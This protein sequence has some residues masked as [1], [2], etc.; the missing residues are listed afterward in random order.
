M[1]YNK[2]ESL[3]QYGDWDE[4]SDSHPAMKWMHE[5]TNVYDK[6]SPHPSLSLL[7]RTTKDC[8]AQ[9]VVSEDLF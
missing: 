6:V 1:S 5:Y 9:Q 7:K 8:G 4:K 2:K 3:V